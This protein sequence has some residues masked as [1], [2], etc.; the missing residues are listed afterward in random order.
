L[1]QGSLTQTTIQKQ[2]NL[3]NEIEKNFDPKNYISVGVSERDVLMYH[4][5][6]KLFSGT[7]IGCLTPGDLKQALQLF[8]YN[9]KKNVIYKL[10]ANIDQDES[11]GISFEEFLKIMTDVKRP[12][13]EDTADD[14]YDVF[15]AYDVDGKGYI[16]RDDI[17]QSALDLNE[18][19]TEEELEDIMI[20]FDPT[21]E[22]KI[23]F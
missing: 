2:R 23:N 19:L 4:E 22:G 7:G 14:Y 17:R 9:A 6:F 15:L 13:D 11:G 3:Y 1:G 10:I 20:K 16:D 18:N 8:D 12:C 21:G 5:L